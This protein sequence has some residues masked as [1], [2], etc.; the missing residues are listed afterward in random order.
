MK[1]KCF[2]FLFTIFNLFFLS[3]TSVIAQDRS[4]VIIESEQVKLVIGNDG[5]AKSLVFKPTNEECLISKDNTPI[6]SVTQ[7]RPYHNEI[8]LAHPNKR[9]T[10]NANSVRREE[11]KLIV[12]FEL[13]PYDAV[14]RIKETPEYIGFTFEDFRVH[15]DVYPNYLKITPP[16]ATEICFLQL[17][18][19]N[20]EKFGEWLNVSW[21][22]NISINV[23]GTDQF[24]RI[25]ADERN[26]YRIMR[27]DAVKDVKFREVGAA[28]IVSETK[29]LLD[30]IAKVEEDFNLPKGVKSRRNSQTKLS[31]YWSGHVNPT[32]LD[33]HLKY[34]K[35]AGFRN[36]MI[37][38][39][40]FLA[41]Y[42]GDYDYN[43][44][45]YPNGKEDLKKMLNKIEKEGFTPGLHVLHSH[46]GRDSRYVTPIPDH[47]LNVLRH[48][49][50]AKPLGMEDT[51]VYV[52]QNPVESTMADGTRVLKVGTELISYTDFTTTVPYKFTGC[53]RG[54]D[55]TTINAQPMGY[56]FGLLDV[57]EFGATSVYIDQNTN[58]Q[59]EIAEKIADI[60]NIGFKS[61]YFDGSE[62]VN[63]PFWHHVASA[64]HKVFKRLSPQPLFAEG[65]A[66]T[67]FS[68]HMLS[69]GNAFDVFKP[70]TLK[71]ET[72]KWPAEEAPR[73]QEDFTRI[74]FG[75]LGYFLPDEKT[76][77]TQPDMLEFVTSRAAAWD[78]PVSIQ[79]SLERFDKHPRTADNLEVIRR[80]E[81][82]RIQNWLTDEQKLMLQDLK[83]EHILLLNEQN[84]FE[85]LP[86]E[87]I[88][89][90][91]SSNK[92]IRA[93]IFERQNDLYVTYW[94]ISGNK[95]LRLPLNASNIKLYK[96]LGQ[97][98]NI[99]KEQG[100]SVT[101]PLENRL[102]LKASNVSKEQLIDAFTKAVIID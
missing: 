3:H 35:M 40:A 42:L 16:P 50:L 51:E 43:K 5:T 98:E 53:E 62:G 29:D 46:I 34:A 69:G 101:V 97:E 2:V 37:Y 38:Y 4:E 17:P 70:E 20:R 89:E 21:D 1:R 39:P 86:Y 78:C 61:I 59:D 66:K 99:V 9:M 74:N 32:N 49:T 12:G 25:D 68:W 41:G 57:S 48:F 84:D 100:N 22:D 15:P 56:T 75:W 81:E 23:L 80:W 72:S 24:A 7:E 54:I 91:A 27:A 95:K 64:Q 55:Q 19:R 30:K 76:I 47:R 44:S 93:F 73:M 58:L 88:T 28:L 31:Y 33:Q 92:E 90:T 67:H 65:A 13:V 36:F 14:I 6:F 96:N 94:H 11:D 63:D 85:L 10:F 26:G 60:Y 82:V 87:H 79:A 71:E 83:Q 102:Y 52:E 45:L 8:K 18:I 77:G